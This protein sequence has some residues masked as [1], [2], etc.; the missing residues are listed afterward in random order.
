MIFAFKLKAMCLE[1]HHVYFSHGKISLKF[2]YIS[3][4]KVNWLW[5]I[6]L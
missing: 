6:K 4:I 2:K 5:K 3:L 1:M